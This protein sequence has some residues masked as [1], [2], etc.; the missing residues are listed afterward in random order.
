MNTEHEELMISI[1]GM[2]DMHLSHRVKGATVDEVIENWKTH[3]ASPIPAIVGEREV[4]DLG[5][6]SLC[7][8][9]VLLGKK[10]VR[11]VGKMVHPDWNTRA[12]SSE[13]DVEQYRQALL[14]DPDIPRLL[15]EGKFR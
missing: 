15:A 8:A 11:R 13:Q 14:V 9:T 6:S 3:I 7:P 10:E 4:E 1:V 2:Y 5:P 12:P